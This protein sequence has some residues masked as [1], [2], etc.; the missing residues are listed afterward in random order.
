MVV[1]LID[2]DRRLAAR[3]SYRYRCTPRSRPGLL[4]VNVGRACSL[5]STTRLL[6]VCFYY[7]TEGGQQVRQGHLD[8]QTSSCGVPPRWQSARFTG[9]VIA[10][11]L[12]RRA[13][14]GIKVYG[15]HSKPASG[16]TYGTARNRAVYDSIRYILARETQREHISAIFGVTYCTSL[17]EKL[18]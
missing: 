5:A 10:S 14:Q 12:P 18:A 7:V 15:T 13:R 17:D 9:R 11:Q 4:P 1:D 2:V 8:V 6:G 3:R 16:R